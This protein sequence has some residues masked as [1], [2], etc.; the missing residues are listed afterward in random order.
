MIKDIIFGGFILVV[1]L[2]MI[3]APLFVLI[4][5]IKDKKIDKDIAEE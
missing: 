1:N 3:S 5:I 2:A 4:E